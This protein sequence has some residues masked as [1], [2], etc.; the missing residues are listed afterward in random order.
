MAPQRLFKPTERKQTNASPNPVWQPHAQKHP[1]LQLQQTVGN[2][3]FQQLL[4]SGVL[5]TNFVVSQPGD[6]QEQVAE[7]VAQLAPQ[8]MRLLRRQPVEQEG[9]APL[10]LATATPPPI[11][12]V[13][14]AMQGRN[15]AS[16]SGGQPKRA[17]DSEKAFAPLVKKETEALPAVE[18]AAEESAAEAPTGEETLQSPATPEKAP[19]SPEEDAEYQTVVVQVEIKARHEKTPSKQPE[20]KQTETKLAANLTPEKIAQQNAYDTHFKRMEQVP[21]HELTHQLTV[22]QFI[23]EFKATSD[24]LAE[25]LPENKEKHGTVQTIVEFATGKAT[26]T[27]EVANQN[28]AYSDPLRTEVQKAASE[29]EKKTQESKT[30]EL[31][32]DPAG[33]TPTIKDAATAAPKPKMEDEISL[34]D[35]SRALDDALLNHNVSGQ[36]LNIDEGSLAFPISGEKTFDEA[37]EAKRKAQDEI[38]KAKPRYREKEMGE[39]SKAQGD[40]QSLVSTGLQGYHLSRS[41][42]FGLVLK[43]QQIHEGNIETG[44]GD[45]F[46]EFQSIYEKTKG[47]VNK[48]LST[49]SGIEK[50]FENI[51]RKAEERFQSLVKNDLEYIYTPGFFDYSDWKDKHA[52]EIKAK[53]EELLSGGEYSDHGRLV[54]HMKAVKIVQDISAV[55]LFSTA[56][57]E[58]IY[59]V[60]TEVREQIA[61]KVV[62]TLKAAKKDI[63]DGENQ[64]DEAYQRLSPKEREELRMYLMLS[65][66]SFRL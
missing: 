16:R 32:V 56:K 43:T 40:M 30:Y 45:F 20:Q 49:L 58:F 26:A 24:K 66:A 11:P 41:K 63:T 22:E 9:N 59:T 35:H 19:A 64:V 13:A 57:S 5:Q 14:P 51:L 29:Y 50:T 39:I 23:A 15:D 25:K 18:S 46:K 28:K 52:S 34:D 48:K 21:S 42:N 54:V 1:L 36:P 33:S 60:T 12:E 62:E 53:F 6:G 61:N 37:G 31:K 44:K 7:Q 4:R 65:E 55:R 8:V 2:Q 38:E 10:V 27:Q 47:L 17:A 3:A